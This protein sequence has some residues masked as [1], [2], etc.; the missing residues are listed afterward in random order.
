MRGL[1]GSALAAAATGGARLDVGRSGRRG[2]AHS[3]LTG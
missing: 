2:T 1:A 3:C